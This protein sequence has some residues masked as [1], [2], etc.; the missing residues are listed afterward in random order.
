MKTT[1]QPMANHQSDSVCAF[2]RLQAFAMSGTKASPSSFV[3]SISPRSGE[4]VST[5]LSSLFENATTIPTMNAPSG[6]FAEVYEKLLP[7]LLQCFVIVTLGYV[8]GRS[9]LVPQS[10]T[11][12]LQMTVSYFFLPAL[13]FRSLATIDLYMV[14]LKFLA[15]I[16]IGKMIIFVS[17][18]LLTWLLKRENRA[19]FAGLFAIFCSQSNDFALGYPLVSYLYEKDHPEFSHYLYLIAPIQLMI[20]N[21]IGFILME[22]GRISNDQRPV[23]CQPRPS[24]HLRRTMMGVLKNPIIVMTAAGIAANFAFQRKLPLVIATIV[25]PLGAGF[26]ACAL[27]LLGQNMVGGFDTMC[28]YTL[29]IT[30]LLVCVKVLA[31]PIIIRE[32]ISHI[33]IPDNAYTDF[34]FLYG[35]LPP[36]P[37]VAIFATQF[38]LPKDAVSAGVVLGTFVSAPLIFITATMSKISDNPSYQQTLSTAISCTS[39]VALPFCLWTMFVLLPK[40]KRVTHSSTM[41]LLAAQTFTSLGGLMLFWMSEDRNVLFHIHTAVS[42]SGIFASRIWTAVIAVVLM[43]SHQRSLCYVLKIRSTLI[44][45]GFAASLIGTLILIAGIPFGSHQPLVHDPNFHLGRLQAAVALIVLLVSFL[46][47]LYGLVRQQRFRSRDEYRPILFPDD[48]ENNSTTTVRNLSPSSGKLP[49]VSSL[50]ASTNALRTS[51]NLCA[52]CLCLKDS[53]QP[54][55]GQDLVLDL[56]DIGKPK[57]IKRKVPRVRR[58]SEKQAGANGEIISEEL[59]ASGSRFNPLHC[60]PTYHCTVIERKACVSTVKAYLNQVYKGEEVT[61]P[62]V[63][64]HQSFRHVCLLIMLLF[65]MLI[66]IAVCLWQLL[67][68]RPSGIL[69]ELEFLDIVFNYGQGILTFIVFGADAS[70]VL[71]PFLGILDVFF[72]RGVDLPAFCE[73]SVEVKQQCEQFRI[74]HMDICASDICPDVDVESVVFSGQQM[75]D[76]LCLVGLARTRDDAVSYGRALLEGRTIAHV[77]NAKHFEDDVHMYRFI[78]YPPCAAM[79]INS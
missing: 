75:C 58:L 11:K 1:V 16:F 69:L 38:C 46:L 65:S 50:S 24:S 37:T 22:Y 6:T 15:S 66:G 57:F 48:G 60:G 13:V 8:S 77:A 12:G 74:Y 43:L 23:Q 27:F 78:S 61:E 41:W 28:K 64:L 68:E 36:A 26:T 76:W 44:F 19:S 17:T 79:V 2:I 55:S 51:T 70:C 54:N 39:L 30:T 29:L 21:P 34:G 71:F 9:R 67:I 5:V 63:D 10:E 40:R 42:M 7:V 53:K 72:C 62:E 33:G 52:N 20:L 31:A 47:S 56:E 4:D 25:E 73:L 18:G 14:N 3:V 32:V 59:I 35:M 45:A 49:R